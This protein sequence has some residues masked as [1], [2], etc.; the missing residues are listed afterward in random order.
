MTLGWRAGAVA[1]DSSR[2]VPTKKEHQRNRIKCVRFIFWRQAVY[3]LVYLSRFGGG[4]SSNQSCRA[5][6]REILLLLNLWLAS[7]A[8]WPTGRK[9]TGVKRLAFHQTKSVKASRHLPGAIFLSAWPRARCDLA[10]FCLVIALGFSLA[11]WSRAEWQH[12]RLKSFGYADRLG[13][14]PRGAVILGKDGIL[15]GTCAEGGLENGGVIF[16][17]DP[18]SSG[19]EVLHHFTSF[20]SNDGMYPAA[21]LLEGS[22]GSLYGTTL[23]G[24]SN[25]IGTIFRINKD[26]GGYLVLHHFGSTNSESGP[27]LGAGLIEGRDGS[28]Y[29]TTRAGGTNSGTIFRLKRTAPNTKKSMYLPSMRAKAPLRAP[30][31]WKDKMEL[32]TGQRRRTIPGTAQCSASM[33][34]GAAFKLCIDLPRTP[35]TAGT[36]LRR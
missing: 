34:R 31:C 27:L 24:G 12:V 20:P 21:A 18:L 10:I 22:D 23:Y 35:R 26:G 11:P 2:S 14:H 29:G 28:L 1:A 16:K 3:A 9:S 33:R 8:L 17:A 19:I 36:L 7:S 15:Y 5:G 4:D 25:A 32:C 13:H 6:L 30:L